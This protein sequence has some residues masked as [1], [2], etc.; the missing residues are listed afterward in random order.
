MLGGSAEIRQR[1]PG[2]MK[3]Y[4][5]I[6]KDVR[7]VPV[8]AF[9]KLD[10]SNVRAEWSR[11]K[12]F[13]KFGSRTQ[14]ISDEQPFLTE[15]PDLIR[16]KYEKDVTDILRKE[17]CESAILFFEFWGQNSFAGTHVVEPHTVTL[18]D[19]AP[20]KKGI[21]YPA[22]YLK[23]FMGLDIAKLLYYGN[24][25]QEFCEMVSGSTLDGMTFEGV[26]CKAP[27]GRTPTPIM[28]KVKSN[29]WVT[30]LKDYCKGDEQLFDRLA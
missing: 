27:N 18:F 15:A 23:L 30:K 5:T 22:D 12:G 10:G 29:A 21:L 8:Y 26:V 6:P 3:D 20:Y 28:F 1:D 9:D 24:P 14:L 16:A 19:V 11:K 2:S 7:H 4:P 25:T 17:R 13:H